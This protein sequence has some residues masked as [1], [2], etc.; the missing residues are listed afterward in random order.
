MLVPLGLAG[1]VGDDV[2]RFVKAEDVGVDH[3][4][5]LGR[6]LLVDA[7]E[8]FEVIGPSS[9][10]SRHLT[11]RF[12]FV[13]TSLS[14]K[15]SCPGRKRRRNEYAQKII[16]RGEGEGGTVCSDDDAAS[17]ANR[18]DRLEDEATQLVASRRPRLSRNGRLGAGESRH[19][20]SAGGA[21]L[22]EHPPQQRRSLLGV[23]ND[24]GRCPSS[25]SRGRND[26][27]ID[28]AQSELIRD[29]SGH[30]VAAG[31]I[32]MRDADQRPR[33]LP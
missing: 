16:S 1:G 25:L 7:V 11:R 14:S 3:E 13:E 28:V 6:N 27:L 20:G 12:P 32:A 21:E 2:R 9:I 15:A 8:P 29:K 18:L 33:H 4:V 24:V 5:V 30:F 19:S 17:R 31:A 23:G 26:V 22:F 10:R